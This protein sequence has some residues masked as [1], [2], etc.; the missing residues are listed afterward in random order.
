MVS[1]EEETHILVIYYSAQEAN[2][3]H[4]Q[5]HSNTVENL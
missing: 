4:L 5:V 1:K 2:G 3:H